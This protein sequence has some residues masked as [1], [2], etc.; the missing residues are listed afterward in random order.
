MSVAGKAVAD[1]AMMSESAI[2][3]EVQ[4]ILAQFNTEIP[5]RIVKHV[6]QEIARRIGMNDGDAASGFVFDGKIWLVRSGI[7]DANA[8][9]RVLFHELLHFAMRRFMPTEQYIG[10]MKDLYDSDKT[11]RNV[12]NSAFHR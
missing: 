1:A 12:A 10:T 3:S 9:R 11:I 8:L 6:P 2:V 5:V 7:G 4:P